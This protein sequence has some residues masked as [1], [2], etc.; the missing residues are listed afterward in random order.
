MDANP[1][2]DNYERYD[3]LVGH[4]P[5]GTSVHNMA[6]W[7]QMVDSGQFK[8]YDWGTSALNMK[9]YNQTTPPVWNLS[10]IRVKMRFFGGT[11]DELADITDLNAM[12]DDL[13]KGVK[14]FFKMY[15][16]GHCTFMW[17]KVTSPW[18]NDVFSLLGSSSNLIS[19][20]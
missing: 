6:H 12:W 19:E 15:A 13:S 11:S 14:E 16:A 2:L 1:D 4:D 7:K 18:M 20:D 17:G 3:V 5:A 8:A 10:N 9:H